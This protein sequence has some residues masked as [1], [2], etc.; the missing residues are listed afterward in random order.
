[1]RICLLIFLIIPFS[2]Y[3]QINQT[4]GNGLRQGRWEK[5]Q[6]NGRLLYE[7]SF[8]DGKPVGE[9]KR[10]HPG[11]Q[12]KAV[13]QYQPG[14]DSAFARLF[15]EWGAKVAEGIYLNEK[16]EGLWT[17]FAENR[18]VSEENYLQGIKH[19]I[20]RKFYKTGEV[21]E[22]AEW[23]NGKQEGNYTVFF[24]NGQPF[25]QCKMSNNQRNGL[26]LS[27]FTNG[28]VELEA[29][30][31]NGLRHGEWK[32][33]RETGEPWYTLNYDNGKLLNPEVRDSIA[34]QMLKAFEN[35]GEPYVDPEKYLEDPSEYL[36]KKNVFR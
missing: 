12:V 18:K 13:I 26:F 17:Y 22:E 19:G 14:S 20:S 16:K 28:K 33:Y 11:G 29:H 4:D 21:L 10:Y 9:W 35:R 7:G 24:K 1:M 32:Y 15:D 27:Y 34:S 2:V 5:R 30:Y 8:K 36:M 31:K 23:N 25:M 3:A 6:P